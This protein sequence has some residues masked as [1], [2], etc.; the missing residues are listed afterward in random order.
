MTNEPSCADAIV[1]PSIIDSSREPNMTPTDR[2][3]G[4]RARPPLAQLRQEAGLTQQ[5]VVDQ[6]GIA[7]PTLDVIRRLALALTV[8]TDELIFG[9]D[10]RG[11]DDDFRL[12]F[13][14]LADFDPR[15]RKSPKPSSSPSSSSTRPAAGPP[16]RS[17]PLRDMREYES[18]AKSSG[19]ASCS[20]TYDSSAL[21]VI[22]LAHFRIERRKN[23]KVSLQ[24]VARVLL[25]RGG[26]CTEQRQCS[27]WTSFGKHL[28]NR[29]ESVRSKD[30]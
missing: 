1:P 13:E 4:K 23:S 30:Q 11:S 6:L 15:K 5:A 2:Q 19:R 12:Q 28:P 24:H 25:Q 3:F 26:I 20:R 21:R 10:A 27:L 9:A 29:R 8:S 22:S 7:Q 16:R 17:V 18:P 14:A